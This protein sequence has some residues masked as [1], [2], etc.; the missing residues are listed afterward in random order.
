MINVG[1]WEN[2]SKT[3]RGDVMALKQD[4]MTDKERLEALFNYRMPDRVPLGNQFCGVGFNTVNAGS[5]I[6]D[7]YGDPEKSFHALLKATEQYGWDQILQIYFHTVYGASDFGGKVRFPKGEYEG[8]LVIESHPVTSEKDVE[9]LQMPDSKTAGFIPKAMQFAE[10]QEAHGLPVTFYSHSPFGMATNICDI[11]LFFRWTAKKPKL[12]E[13]LIQMAMEH[14]FNVLDYWVERFGA[15]RLN[16]WMSTPYET[17][18]LISPKLFE[19]LALPYHVEYHARL[20]SLGIKRFCY[21]I[22]GD[23]NLSLPYLSEVLPWHHP[24]VLSFGHEVDLEMASKYFPE[25][26][27]YGNI[28]PT[29]IQVGTPQQVYELSRTTIE[30]GKKA[31]G[32]FILGP[33]CDIPPLTPPENMHAITRAV[34]DFGWYD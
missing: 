7:A 1:K 3:E 4:K 15:E 6:T 21:H 22:C 29:V 8:G 5:T 23:Q 12:C 33:G 20:R 19:R 9:I 32:G 16:V 13:R 10:L 14:I 18:Q 34:N 27:I 24:S 30:K 31:P 11:A 28:E 2:H 26:I 25:D 17:N